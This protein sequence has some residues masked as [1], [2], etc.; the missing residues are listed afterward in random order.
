MPETGGTS[1]RIRLVP[2]SEPRHTPLGTNQK[3]KI[4]NQKSKI[5]VFCVTPRT[6]EVPPLEHT[7]FLIFDFCFLLFALCPDGVSVERIQ[8]DALVRH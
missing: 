6:A 8:A 1:E 7:D 5:K 4:K 3:S 2:T